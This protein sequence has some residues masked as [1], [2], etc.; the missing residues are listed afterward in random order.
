MKLLSCSL[1][2]TVLVIVVVSKYSS[3][4]SLQKPKP[5]I[6]NKCCGEKQILTSENH[7]CG[8]GSDDDWWPLIFQIM[9]KSY[10]EPKGTAPR[11]MKYRELRPHCNN[12][13][14]YAGSH[15]MALFSNGTLYLSEKH[16][17]IDPQHFCVDK[18]AAIVCDPESVQT[19]RKSLKVRKCCVKN[20]IYRAIENTCTPSGALPP[21]DAEFTLNSTDADVLFGFPECKISKYFTIAETFNESNL[22]KDTN[23]L[24]L[25][26]GKKLEWKDFC[27]EHVDNRSDTTLHVFTCADHLSV[28]RNTQE[29]SHTVKCWQFSS[30]RL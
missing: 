24:I 23:R 6:V 7:R 20:A 13:E 22:D 26:T 5:T 4:I 30:L 12:P 9:K 19:N 11:F 1:F 25:K 17:F 3:A 8:V 2:I 10:W 18:D 14:F 21:T 16:K 29:L 28:S 15:K 27:I